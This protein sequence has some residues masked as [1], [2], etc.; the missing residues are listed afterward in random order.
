MQ[1][2]N[3][4]GIVLGACYMGAVVAAMF[5]RTQWSLAAR[6]MVVVGAIIVVQAALTAFR[7]LRANGMLA[8]RN[9]PTLAEARAASELRGELAGKSSH[10]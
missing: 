1:I 4:L 9:A 7:L 5:S 3:R 2:R 8:R 6:L 10:A